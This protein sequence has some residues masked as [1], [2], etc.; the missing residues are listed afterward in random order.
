MIFGIDTS[1]A[2]GS[3]A[4]QVALDDERT[5]F[6]YARVCYG[7]DPADDDGPAF[8]AAHDACKAR[9]VPFLSYI[10]WLMGQDGA[11]QAQHYLDAGNGRFGL[12]A[13]V[14]VE[15]SSGVLGWG[16]S[17]EQ[18]IENLSKALAAIAAKIGQPIIYTN[19]D[20][21]GTYFA[22]TDA[23]SGHRFIVAQYGVEPGQFDPIPGIKEVV[24]HQFSDGTGQ[25]PIS[26]LSTPANNVDRD[27]LIAPNFSMLGRR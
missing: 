2:N 8:T 6:V 19:G 13:I 25:T 18:R 24:I 5:K 21:W 23:F 15:E 12:G 22:N 4:W 27:V 9:G 1:Y 10:F 26:G 20:T 7:Q 17:V 3:P 16:S 11:A 14:D